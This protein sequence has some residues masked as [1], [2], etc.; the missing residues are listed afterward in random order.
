LLEW[1]YIDGLTVR[2]LGIKTGTSY[3]TVSIRIQNAESFIDG[4]LCALDIGW[5]WTGSAKRKYH[6]A[7]SENLCHDK[8]DYCV[9]S[10]HFDT[11]LNIDPASNGGVFAFWRFKCWHQ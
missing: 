7:K 10:G 2:E 3:N 1:Y 8:V 5:K 9:K 11:P 4:I 6:S